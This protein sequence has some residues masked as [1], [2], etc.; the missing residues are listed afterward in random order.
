[1]NNHKFELLLRIQTL[2]SGDLLTCLLGW[3]DCL[4]CLGPSLTSNS[5]RGW[6]E[7]TFTQKKD[8]DLTLQGGAQE[9]SLFYTSFIIRKHLLKHW[10]VLR[11]KYFVISK[12]L[13]FEEEFL[14]CFFA[15]ID[16]CTE[17]PSVCG[18][19]AI[20]NNHPGTFRCECVEGYQFS[21]QGTCVGKFPR[22]L[23][24]TF[25]PML[26]DGPNA[27][28]GC[29]CRWWPWPGCKDPHVAT[30][31]GIYKDESDWA[32]SSS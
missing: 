15:D 25:V 20:C 9:A 1:M 26:C 14:K 29:C 11:Q 22:W 6:G 12:S 16:E 24:K 3:C 18:S 2:V 28:T 8:L 21:D 31:R 7:D 17:Q 13:M 10:P 23:V 30:G 5:K 19:H 4:I 32:Q 27:N